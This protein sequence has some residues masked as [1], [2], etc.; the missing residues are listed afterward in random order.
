DLVRECILA[1][2]IIEGVVETMK[3]NKEKMEYWCNVGFIG[4]TTLL[5]QIA[6]NYGVPFRLSKMIVERSVK[7]SQGQEKVTFEAVKKAL[8]ELEIDIAITP[9]QVM[10]WQD[11]TAIINITKSFGGPSFAMNKIAVSLLRKEA[12]ELQ[13]W[14]KKKE[15]QRIKSDQLLVTEIATIRK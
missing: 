8:K 1:P 15:A 7:Y 12:G 13:K 9:E 6:A 10:G 11:P 14:L 2:K 5:E 4:T 3:V